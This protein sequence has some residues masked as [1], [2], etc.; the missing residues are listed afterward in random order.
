MLKRWS[1]PTEAVVERLRPNT[2]GS[3]AFRSR[4]NARTTVIVEGK[5]DEHW[6]PIPITRLPKD[7]VVEF[8]VNYKGCRRYPAGKALGTSRRISS[9]GLAGAIGTKGW[10]DEYRSDRNRR[11]N[12]GK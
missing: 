12:L 5:P 6:R 7:A 10:G 8:S 3:E 4:D 11:V 9:G 1:D 2:P